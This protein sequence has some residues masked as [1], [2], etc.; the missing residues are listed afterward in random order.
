MT[1]APELYTTIRGHLAKEESIV[2]WAVTV[3]Q[4]CNQLVEAALK[5]SEL[6]E[7][8]R[9]NLAIGPMD[10]FLQQAAVYLRGMI[11][12]E[13]LADGTPL[14]SFFSDAEAAIVYEGCAILFDAEIFMPDDLSEE[15]FGRFHEAAVLGGSVHIFDLAVDALNYLEEEIKKAEMIDRIKSIINALQEEDAA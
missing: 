15:L 1:D 5:L 13:R 9:D 8:L 6:S 4:A 3:E 14:R 12:V 2:F 10:A 11:N 7:E